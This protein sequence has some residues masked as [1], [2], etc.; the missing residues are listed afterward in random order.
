MADRGQLLPRCH[1][2]VQ[3]A[4]E[5]VNLLG[6]AKEWFGHGVGRSPCAQSIGK[7][8]LCYIVLFSS[9]TSAPGSPGNYL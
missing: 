6:S 9:E 3:I 7:F 2:L 5:T 1:L 8:S 4:N